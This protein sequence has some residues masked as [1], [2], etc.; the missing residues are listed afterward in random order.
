M[1]G[2]TVDH[3]TPL[4]VLSIFFIVFLVDYSKQ[5]EMDSLTKDGEAALTFFYDA[6]PKM[7]LLV[8]KVFD[9]PMGTTRVVE[10]VPMSLIFNPDG[11][12]GEFALVELFR[13]FTL[14][15]GAGK[16]VPVYSPYD[17]EKFHFFYRMF[18]HS[19][20]NHRAI[21]K[22]S[23]I[24]CYRYADETDDNGE[25]IWYSHF[26]GTARD[27]S[28][29]KVPARVLTIA[30]DETI[31]GPID[32][33][34]GDA[35][36]RINN[37]R[38]YIPAMQNCDL[39]P[40]LDPDGVLKEIEEWMEKAVKEFTDVEIVMAS[41][42][43]FVGPAPSIPPVPLVPNVTKEADNGDLVA[44]EEA[45]D[46]GP[47]APLVA[48]RVSGPLVPARASVPL[49]RVW[50]N[51]KENGDNGIINKNNNKKKKSMKRKAPKKVNNN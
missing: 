41:V 46:D 45:R 7:F 3:G 49:P 31:N 22:G 40:L 36:F 9:S 32:F 6:T 44:E 43:E 8:G 12:Q 1:T 42:N 48:A 26:N 37:H 29:K 23:V 25:Y 47:S 11:D 4:L 28:G 38:L 20:Q 30:F 19:V 16:K 24:H 5:P 15:D 33:K 51:N 2:C 39:I 10:T 34:D 13:N 14:T 35:T 50:T 27:D 17:R 18:L 21:K